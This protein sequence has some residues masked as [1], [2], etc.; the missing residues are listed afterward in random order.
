MANVNHFIDWT[1]AKYLVKSSG[2]GG[3]MTLD[4][5]FR[6]RDTKPT[7]LG[8]FALLPGVSPAVPLCSWLRR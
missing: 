6:Q 7:W 3:E 5:D 2:L 1:T 8:S 4:D